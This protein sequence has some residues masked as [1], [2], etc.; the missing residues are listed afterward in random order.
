MIGRTG[1]RPVTP[2]PAAG[3]R[4]G[5]QRAP[6]HRITVAEVDRRLAGGVVLLVVLVAAVVAPNFSQLRIAGRAVQISVP[7]APVAGDCVTSLPDVN[8]L[9]REGNFGIGDEIELPV[10]EFGSCTGAI[11]GEV[12]SV[13]DGVTLTRDVPATDY[14]KDLSQCGLDSIDYTGSIPPIVDGSP[15][16]PGNVWSPALNFQTTSIG[17]SPLQRSVGQRWLACVIGAPAAHPYEGSLR[18][19]LTTGAVPWNFAN[20]W[21]SE[22]MRDVDQVSCDRP[23]AVE[24]L[25]TTGLGSTPQ[26]ATEV[27]H[28][29][30]VIAG[31]MIRTADPTRGGALRYT[32]L[33]FDQTISPVPPTEEVLRD[34]YITCIVVAR[35]GLVLTDTLVGIGDGPLPTG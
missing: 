29:C 8:R 27:L 33:D 15:G 21:R 11:R 32:I 17:P 28:S 4:A 26:T 20:C 14:Q 25:A 12:V 16:R 10:A 2:D 34:T 24:L 19:V 23:H 6:R 18:D 5:R 13:L 22:A 31:R 1:D 30:S 9:L 7:A 35:A 3:V